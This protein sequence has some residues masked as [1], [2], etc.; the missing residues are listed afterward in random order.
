MTAKT[1]A[2]NA[3]ALKAA[4][5]AHKD[6]SGKFTR[7]M[8][9]H[10]ADFFGLKPMQLVWQLEKAGIIRRG[11]WAWFKDNGGITQQNIDQARAEAASHRDRLWASL[12]MLR[13][14]RTA[15]EKVVTRHTVADFERAIEAALTAPS[16]LPPIEALADAIDAHDA[17]HASDCKDD[18]ALMAFLCKRGTPPNAVIVEAARAYLE[19]SCK[20]N[21]DSF[22]GQDGH[23]KKSVEWSYGNDG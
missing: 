21:A 22:A 8:A 23:V 1:T 5:E 7:R 2:L 19:A 4:F 15:L 13:H 20:E 17:Y 11:S 3:E 10:I 14:N 12:A 18:S 16:T 6:G 9:I